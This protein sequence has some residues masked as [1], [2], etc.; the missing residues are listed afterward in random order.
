M[1]ITINDVVQVFYFL[2]IEPMEQFKIYD[3]QTEIVLKNK[4]CL[5]NYLDLYKIDKDG[6][7]HPSII[8][9]LSL[10][11]GEMEIIKIEG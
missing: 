8:S 4:Y 9:F 10:L 6:D 2:N 3:K 7:F 5:T 1:L 11:N